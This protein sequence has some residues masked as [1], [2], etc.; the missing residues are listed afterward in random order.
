VIRATGDVTIKNSRIVGTL[1]VFAP[2]FKVILD[3]DLVMEPARSDYPAL[4]VTAN[5]LVIQS[6]STSV[7]SESSAGV[8]FNPAGA[9]AAG[10]TDSD[11]V[12]QYPNLLKGLIHV[13]GRV[14]IKSSLNIRG[15]IISESTAAAD[16]IDVENAS[17]MIK[18][19]SS[20]FTNPPQGYTSSVKMVPVSGSI[21]QVV[22]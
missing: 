1:V 20:L 11:L 13:T 2:G 7:L 12:D 19:D 5:E 17:P 10:V 21:R 16:A 6:G 14:N 18:Y 8:N 15:A 3:N 9:P 4:I 22:D